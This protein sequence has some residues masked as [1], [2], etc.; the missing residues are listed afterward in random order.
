MLLDDEEAG[1]AEWLDL[2]EECQA[3]WQ[4]ADCQ[5][6]IRFIKG[7][8]LSPLAVGYVQ[9][10]TADLYRQQGEWAAASTTYQRA[11]RTFQELDQ[12]LDEA[13]VCNNFALALQEQRNYPQATRHYQEALRLY[14]EEEATASIAHVLANLGNIAYEQGHWQQAA[15]YYHQSAT[16]LETAD[17]PSDLASIYNS[18]GVAY[19]ELGD[20]ETAENH[21]LRCADLLD[22]LEVAY[23]VRG[24]R[25]MSNLGQ[26]YGKQTQ[27]DKAIH[28][29][30]SALDIAQTIDDPFQE[31]KVWNNLG[32]VYTQ[33]GEAEAAVNSYQ[34]SLE[35]AQQLGDHQRELIALNN[36]GA[37]YADLEAFALAKSCYQNGLALSQERNEPYGVARALNNLGAL[38][39]QQGDLDTAIAYYQQ[40]ADMA[41]SIG[42]LYRATLTLINIASLYEQQLQTVAAQ[43]CFDRAWAM[44]ETEGYDDHLA[45]LC[46]LRGDTSFQQRA[47][48]PDA[49]RWFA[50]ACRYAIRHNPHTL[51][52]ITQ[53][54]ASHLD[55]LQKHQP[56]AAQ[57]FAQFLLTAEVGEA[58][59]T[60]LPI[61]VK[62]LRETAVISST[63]PS[64][65]PTNDT[66]MSKDK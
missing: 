25:V 58:L 37:A 63:T 12:P 55:R 65:M 46:T 44:A 23:S 20:L 34:R 51:Q 52:Q 29:F 8:P 1:L 3:A 36:I 27:W 42:H 66:A 16:Q 31:G 30:E 39:A 50:Q 7:M 28:C 49:Y 59:S 22:D 54:I 4:F 35:L 18:L 17:L 33:Q 24:L 11:R 43:P 56:F 13:A 61:F 32:T 38:A 64:K 2:L 62:M 45:S 6:L 47:T 41:E 5:Q 26:L 21:Y 15:D 53:H 10:A 48:Y 60:Q 57:A 9:Q 19:E 14:K 40:S